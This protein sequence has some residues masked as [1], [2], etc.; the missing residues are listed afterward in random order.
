MMEGDKPLV[1]VLMTSYN[2]EK[3]IGEAIESVLNST[4]QQWELIIVDDQ[5][6]DRTV[7]IARSYEQKDKRVKVYINE[8]NLGDYPNRNKAASYAKGK[9][10]KYVDSDDLVYSYC[11]EL[12]VC[13]MEKFPEA[14]Y[15]LCTI[16]PLKEQMFPIYLTPVEAYRSY[17]SGKIG[18][19]DRAPLSAIIKKEAFDTLG[20]FS[21]KQH[22]GDFELW[23]VLSRYFSV[24]LMPEGMVWNREHHEQQM[25]ANRN[26][27]F[28]LYKYLNLSLKLLNHP[29]CPLKDNELREVLKRKKVQKIKFFIYLL[30]KLRFKNLYYSLRLE[31]EK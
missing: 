26:N 14:G 23:Q 27:P 25:Q 28:V 31:I 13:F 5:S 4:Y 6:T 12:L 3:Y 17:Y 15:G 10:L 24:V 21:G 1:S 9:Y 11:L 29:E 20:G 7:E 30:K 18:L 2:R 16:P 19:F 8:K 22:V